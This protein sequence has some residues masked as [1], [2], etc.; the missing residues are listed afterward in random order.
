[1]KK[2]LYRL[3]LE[4]THNPLYNYMLKKAATHTWSRKA[5]PSFSKTFKINTEEVARQPAEFQHLNDFF[6][7]ELK[8]GARP[9]SQA[10]N[11]IVSP[12]DGVLSEVGDITDKTLMHIKQKPHSLNTM[13]GLKGA[14]NTYLG[15]KYFVFYLSPKDYHRIHAP[16]SGHV[17][18]RWALGRYS[19]PVNHL[20][21]YFG[22]E[23]LATNYRLITEFES[24]KHRF[25][26]VK[27]GALNVN[28][29]HLSHTEPYSQK[30]EEIGYFSFGST[31]VL[32]FQQNTIELAQ[33]I[34]D[35]N[36]SN[37]PVKQGET[38]AS[39][40]NHEE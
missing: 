28:S 19:E 37:V 14:V 16:Y 25:A 27:I 22:Q 8:E 11:E 10:V 36:K 30:G 40:V 29:I 3:M 34:A 20:G 2:R 39:W 1:M 15:G 9:V 32:L 26:V 21:F 4:L 17:R 13:L 24:S 23:P 31:V 12:V 18:R 38:I 35:T 7:R 5:I 33:W 6:S